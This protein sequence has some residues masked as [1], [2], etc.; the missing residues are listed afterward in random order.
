M[1]NLINADDLVEQIQKRDLEVQQSQKE[2]VILWIN[3]GLDMM[4]LSKEYK[5]S[6]DDISDITGVSQAQISLYISLASDKR[7]VASL[8]PADKNTKRL[9]RFNQK[10]LK[11]LTTL[12][13]VD[14]NS[15]IETGIF[16]KSAKD[17]KSI[18]LPLREQI[19]N[20]RVLIEQ[21]EDEIEALEAEL[22]K[23][24]DTDTIEAELIE[25]PVTDKD[26]VLEAITKAGSGAELARAIGVSKGAVANW[27]N[28]NK[29]LSDDYRTLIMEYLK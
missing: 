26:L 1:N 21:I 22:L 18:E 2:L 7:L 28:G 16:P 14:F 19:N 17:D 4:K 23:E 6:Q 9:E 27:K 3:Q 5:Y 8:S 20:K 15:T 29:N 24:D 25:T 11:K 10:E 13:D 12:N